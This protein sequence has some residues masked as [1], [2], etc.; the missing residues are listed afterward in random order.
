MRRPGAV[1]VGA[2]LVTGALAAF[3]FGA[4][5]AS[6]A[7][8]SRHISPRLAYGFNA[9]DALAAVGHDLWVA[10]RAGNSVTELP[11]P[12]VIGSARSPP[13]ATVQRPDC[14][15]RRRRPCLRRQPGW[16]GDRVQRRQRVVGADDFRQEYHLNKPTALKVDGS[17][18]FIVD[19]A[20]WL[21][22]IDTSNGKFVRTISG[23][24]RLRRPHGDHRRR[25]RSVGRQLQWQF[26]DRGRCQAR[27]VGEETLRAQLRLANRPG[28]AFDGTYLWVTES[29]SNSVTEIN[30]TTGA[31]K[32]G[33]ERRQ[34]RLQ[35]PVGDH[36]RRVPALCGQPSWHLAHGDG[37]RWPRRAR[38]LVHVQ[39]QRA[40]P[41]Q[42]PAGPR[43]ER[44][45]AL[46]RE[47]G[48]QLAAP[49]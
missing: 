20:G 49:R 16:F 39:H 18:L 21:T 23:Q 12:P 41:L 15:S 47:H 45:K 28:I 32:C 17:D 36:H 33:L 37:F 9:P 26:G 11:P 8:V 40:L 25:G 43:R 24:V 38:P 46:G 27:G 29:A 22:E 31:V 7:P 4:G 34:L 3:T 19:S 5:G 42:Q 10:N 6:A 44:G 2:L 13:V 35:Q 1:R 30:A 48:R 14:D